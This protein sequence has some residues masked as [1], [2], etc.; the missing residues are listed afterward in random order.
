MRF[1]VLYNIDYHEEIH[2]SA[3][4]YY[5]AILDQIVALEELGYD[6]AWFGDEVTVWFVSGPANVQVTVSPWATVTL[7]GA[8]S[9]LATETSWFAADAGAA[10]TSRAPVTAANSFIAP[11]A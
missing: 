11:P 9:K 3:S 1:G 4:R 7:A 8:N 2:G 5:G 10:R 6:S